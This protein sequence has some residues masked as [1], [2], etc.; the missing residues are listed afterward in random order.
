MGV[1]GGTRYNYDPRTGVKSDEPSVGDRIINQIGANLLGVNMLADKRKKA[2][3]EAQGAFMDDLGQRLQGQPEGDVQVPIANSQGQDIS[4]AFAP[5][6]QHRAASPPLDVNSA[7]LPALALRAQRLGIPMTQLLE[8]LKAQQPDVKVGPDGTPYNSRSMAGLPTQFRNPQAVNNTVVDLNNPENENRAIPGAPVPGAMPVY[9]NRGRVTDWN[10]PPGVQAAIRQSK[11]AEAGGTAAGA[12]PYDLR[13][14]QGPRGP[15]T[16][17]LQNFLKRG[18][19]LGQSPGDRKY[20]E[21][22]AQAAAGQYKD[23]QT[24]G[25]Q[26]N[27]KIARYGQIKGL[28]GNYEGG[29]FSPAGLEIA[30]ALNSMGWK[31]DPKMSNAQAADA[32]GKQLVLDANGGSLGTGFSNA[33]RDFLVKT[34]PSILQSAGGRGTLIEIGIKTEQRKQDVANKARQ[35]QQRFGRIDAPDATGKTFQDYLDAW[36]ATHPVFQPAT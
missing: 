7:E 8:V 3:A 16:D 5:Q 32:I 27:A 28:L 1:F 31:M 24:A 11:A 9:D 34:V 29:R 6:M 19:I 36:A 13:Q 20:S 21:D 22:T 2:L 17:T 23:I 26:A 10:L 30:S 14:I 25:Q 35:W 33:D 18:P 4:A 15:E 12:A